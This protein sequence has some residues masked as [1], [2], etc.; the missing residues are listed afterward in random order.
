MTSCKQFVSMELPFWKELHKVSEGLL[1][2]LEIELEWLKGRI[3]GK[4]GIIVEKF[5]NI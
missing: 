3:L 2:Q 5:S 1:K 4:F